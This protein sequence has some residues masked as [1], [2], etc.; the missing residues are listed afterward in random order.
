MVLPVETATVEMIAKERAERKAN[1][2]QLPASGPGKRFLKDVMAAMT[3][4]RELAED[5]VDKRTRDYA[6]YQQRS[7]Q[8][9]GGQERAVVAVSPPGMNFFKFSENFKG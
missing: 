3:E 9:Q 8:Q 5:V 4:M 1:V 2:S 6:A 7:G